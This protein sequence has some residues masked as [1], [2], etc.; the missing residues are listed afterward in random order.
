MRSFPL[1]PKK[2]DQARLY[3]KLKIMNNFET[4]TISLLMGTASAVCL[5][6]CRG[7]GLQM[8]DTIEGDVREKLHD[9]RIH[10]PRLRIYLMVWLYS[11]V[12]L[13]L[14]CWVGY[15][16]AIF[17]LLAVCLLGP[18]PWYL[19]RRMAL[20][21]RQRLEDQLADSM[22][23]LA[24][25]VRAGL[26]L[27]QAL[28]ILAQQ[29]PQPIGSEFRQMVAQYSMGRTLEETL[30]EAK[31]RLRSENFSMFA[32]AMLASRESGG[33]L[34]E[35]VERIAQSVREFH[36]LER[37]IQ[38]ETAQT[39][40]S[41]IYMALAPPLILLVYHFVDPLNTERLFTTLPGQLMLA[42][43][44]ILNVVAWLWARTILSPD[45]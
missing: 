7:M 21:R 40:K 14:A 10:V 12:V 34:N 5:W 33:R 2:V 18:L 30:R 41:A 16:N 37:K 23:T 11:L 28:K 31:R 19:L 13:L 38:S 35:T 1:K 42:A 29:S 20:A 27:A 15:G 8:F 32:A 4:S 43:A 36:R 25:A 3:A 45:V 24:G 39:R 44:V 22:T 6:S 26:S 9:M 17:G